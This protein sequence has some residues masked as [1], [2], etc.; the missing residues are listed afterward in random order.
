MNNVGVLVMPC[1]DLYIGHGI[2]MGASARKAGE[3]Y[4]AV[5]FAYKGGGWK[6]VEGGIPSGRKNV[7]RYEASQYAKYRIRLYE[8]ELPK[9]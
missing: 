1:D 2:A 5:R 8:M 6:R 9:S 4:P 3:P 7:F